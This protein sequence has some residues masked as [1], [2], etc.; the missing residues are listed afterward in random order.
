MHYLWKDIDFE[1]VIYKR[2][3]ILWENICLKHHKVDFSFKKLIGLFL[4][5]ILIFKNFI[6][7]KSNQK[8]KFNW[9][10]IGYSWI[11]GRDNVIIFFLKHAMKTWDMNFCREYRKCLKGFRA[12]VAWSA[13]FL[14]LN[15]LKKVSCFL[16]MIGL[17]HIV[18]KIE[19]V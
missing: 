1:D 9:I 15:Y 13:D 5:S 11:W 6:L 14:E 12:G 16:K 10:K 8:M 2:L 4:N 18:S 7:K 17:G 19:W 3:F